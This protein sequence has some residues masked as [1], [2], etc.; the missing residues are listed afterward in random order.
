[1]AEPKCYKMFVSGFATATGGTT[2]AMFLH[3]WR[4]IGW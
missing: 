2:S 3:I 1:M 4:L